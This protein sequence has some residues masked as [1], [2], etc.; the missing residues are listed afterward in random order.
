MPQPPTSSPKKPARTSVRFW[1]WLLDWKTPLL[2]TQR[3]WLSLPHL[4][5]AAAAGNP[6]AARTLARFVT[7]PN[8][9]LVLTQAVQAIHQ[10][11]HPAA[12]AAVWDVW[13]S[14]RS[15]TLQAVL[16]QANRPAAS[17]SL[18]RA[19]SLL[20]LPEQEKSLSSAPPELVTGL[21]QAAADP[22]P[23]LANKA[24]S[25]LS[26]LRRPAAINE[27]CRI[28][29]ETRAQ[30]LSDILDQS[31]Y[32]AEKPPK[33]LVLTALKT[34]QVSPIL[35]GSKEVVSP[36][37]AALQDIDPLLRI[38][39]AACLPAF[40]GQGA[41]D[42][43]CRLWVETRSPDLEK[44]V[45]RAHYLPETPV[46]RLYTALLLGRL[47]L[48]SSISPDL[49]PELLKACQDVNPSIRES[50]VKAAGQLHEITLE[51]LYDLIMDG[52]NPIATALALQYG[53]RPFS[54]DRC[55]MFLFFTE[56]WDE[57]LSFDFDLVLMHAAYLSAQPHL[58]QR[59]AQVI[60]KSGRP[61]LLGI[62]SRAE[63][64]GRQTTFSPPEAE[65][66]SKILIKSG[67]N[68]QLWQLAFS[69][70]PLQSLPLFHHLL[71]QNWHPA[72]PA[73]QEDWR[74][75]SS[76]LS[77]PNPDW[78]TSPPAFPRIVARS[79]LKVGGRVNTVAFSPNLPILAIGTGSRKVVLWNYQ[80]ARV[81]QR[82]STFSHSIGK[83]AYTPSGDL[84]IAET[85]N[86]DDPCS[87][88]LWRNS[89]L[90]NL[91]FHTGGITSLV[92]LDSEHLTTA[93]RDQH[94]KVW[95]L[96]SSNTP[97]DLFLSD[98][99]RGMSVTS[100]L[101]TLA[102]LTEKP[103]F[104]AL[105]T[106]SAL[107]PAP[108]QMARV[109]G[110]SHGLPSCAAF[111]PDFRILLVG[112]YSGSVGVFYRTG[113][114]AKKDRS[115]LNAHQG[116]VVA[117]AFLPGENTFVTAGVDGMIQFYD[118][119]SLTEQI[120]VKE[121][122]GR[123]LSLD[124]SPD[125]RFMA[126]GSDESIITLSDL[127]LPHLSTVLETPLSLNSPRDLSWISALS[128]YTNLPPPCAAWLEYTHILLQHH[129]RYDVQISDPVSLPTGEFDIQLE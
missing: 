36:L 10:I 99:P 41:I 18:L 2:R 74:K 72:S 94:L 123:L 89:T 32:L 25:T 68:D 6:A 112:Y 52:N 107:Q 4:Q 62:L 88:K 98:W 33:L 90:S 7:Q 12:W 55:A 77:T 59:I 121:P 67:E 111:S 113:Q 39:A 43:L 93:G 86:S 5:T 84:L 49:L 128:Q 31:L 105:P 125:G 37:V 24:R 101:S 79:K 20:L 53:Y 83:L 65:A 47:N 124:F 102:L 26:T 16:L 127:R 82:I 100:D 119:P 126:S 23:A 35:S 117:T 110:F 57:Y 87:V 28:W 109:R 103:Q 8:S 51:A 17:P 71:Q 91:G 30:L 92:A 114:R 46:P 81:C 120:Q 69:L 13:F 11:T 3:Q 14:S 34:N 116:R 70:S 27:F 64:T 54:K 60:Q 38:R 19:Y 15:A 48:A 75:I 76:L 95:N 61:E 108:Y 106:L 58:R 85:T 66:F 115:F 97:P 50:A 78:F 22:D 45:L 9:D 129:Y 44:A 29:A 63:L 56:Q 96:D 80:E 42:E 1:Q 118:Y 122:S 21:I 40:T 104:L 73:D